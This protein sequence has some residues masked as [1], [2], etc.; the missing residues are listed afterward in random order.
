MNAPCVVKFDGL[1]KYE[2]CHSMFGT[3][4][5]NTATPNLQS[6]KVGVDGVTF[7]VRLLTVTGPGHH[8]G[9]DI[10]IH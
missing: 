3:K 1:M 10:T 2:I 9:F 4:M 7:S 6:V 8:T 5:H